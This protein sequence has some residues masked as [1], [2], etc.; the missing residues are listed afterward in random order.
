[1]RQLK[2]GEI[3]TLE[4]RMYRIEWSKWANEKAQGNR[5]ILKLVR[6]KELMKLILQQEK[7][8]E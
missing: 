2:I 3:I 7:Q 8:N 5:A 6:E 4:G 1:M